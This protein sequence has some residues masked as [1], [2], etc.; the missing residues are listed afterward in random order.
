MELHPTASRKLLLNCSKNSLKKEIYSKPINSKK[1]LRQRMVQ[2]IYELVPVVF[3]KA[4]MK[5]VV[6]RILK[7]FLFNYQHCGHQLHCHIKQKIIYNSVIYG[8]CSVLSFGI[9]IHH[10]NCKFS[11]KRRKFSDRP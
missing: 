4:A 3:K 8:S 6:D 11:E 10:Q 2:Y 5:A 7:H 1:E 9:R